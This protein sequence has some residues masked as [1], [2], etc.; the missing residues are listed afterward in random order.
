MMVRIDVGAGVSLRS[1]R[2]RSAVAVVVCAST[3]VADRAHDRRRDRRRSSRS[4][5]LVSTER[6]SNDLRRGALASFSSSFF[7]F[8]CELVDEDSS[9]EANADEVAKCLELLGLKVRRAQCNV[10]LRHVM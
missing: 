4:S 10:L 9:G 7:F 8:V 2:E 1:R 3:A 5:L 6:L